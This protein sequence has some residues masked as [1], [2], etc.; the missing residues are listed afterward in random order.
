MISSQ[1]CSFL[2]IEDNAADA[3]LI[4]RVLKKTKKSIQVYQARD[5]EQ[6]LEMLENWPGSLPC[7]LIILLDL[8]LPKVDGLQVVKQIK[9]NE[10]FQC[11]PVIMLTSSDQNEDIQT[12]YK[13][14]ANSYITKS[15][16]FDEFSRKIEILQLYWCS[17]NVYP[18]YTRAE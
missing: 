5:G 16:D 18:H 12:A 17:L 9:S 10:K 14:G 7:P 11:L 8:K 3:E 13:N 4:L 2:L 6:A 15:I 1:I